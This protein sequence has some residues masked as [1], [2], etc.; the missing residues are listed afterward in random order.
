MGFAKPEV[1]LQTV[2]SRSGGTVPQLSPAGPKPAVHRIRSAVPAATA[3]HSL[4]I[5]MP[6]A[7]VLQ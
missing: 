7:E 4:T 1:V 3:K 5:A 6:T 2:Q